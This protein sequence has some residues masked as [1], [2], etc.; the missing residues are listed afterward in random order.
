MDKIKKIVDKK[1]KEKIAALT[2][3]DY[4]FGKIFS[5]NG[6]DFILVGDSLGMTILGNQ[7]TLCVSIDK[8]AY[9]TKSVRKGIS[10]RKTLLISDL[11]FATYFEKYDSI[12]NSSFLLQSG[13]NMV[14]LEGNENWVLETIK[15]LTERNIPVCG[16]I[17]LTPQSINM[18]GS[19][20]IQYKENKKAKKLIEDS[21]KIQENGAKIL[22]VECIPAYLAKSITESLDIPVIGIGAGPFTDGQILVMQ[23]FLGITEKKRTP[24][25][26]KNF[27]KKS[28]SIQNAVKIFI[29]DVKNK[30]FPENQHT[31]F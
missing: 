28:T 17:G 16:H 9:H 8:I 11:P 7:D 30:K 23:D 3:Y 6:I 12:K 20:G 5:K 29:E 14:K 27:L 4:S 19:Y 2:A 26:A 31:Y 13:A 10:N 1:K 25:F 18:I 21:I 15:Y 22:F 24:F